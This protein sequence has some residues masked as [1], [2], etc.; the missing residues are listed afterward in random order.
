MLV[1]KGIRQGVRGP[2]IILNCVV[3]YFDQHLGAG[4]SKRWSKSSFLIFF[5]GEKLKKQQNLTKMF[6]KFAPKRWMK[7][8]P[9][10]LKKTEKIF[11]T[12]PSTSALVQTYK[13]HFFD[14]F[15]CKFVAFFPFF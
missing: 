10:K 4:H 9:S 6:F 11:Q 14:K 2:D 13:N 8:L 12:R 5:I 3:V 7:N 15:C 1:H